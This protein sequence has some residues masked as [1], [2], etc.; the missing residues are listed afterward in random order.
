[1]HSRLKCKLINKSSKK[2][3]ANEKNS[4]CIDLQEK[5][6]SFPIL[7]INKSECCGCSACYS[8]CRKKAISM[9][10]DSKGFEYPEINK[11]K[12]IKCGMCVKVCPIKQ[13]DNSIL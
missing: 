3:S 5:T 8:I 4:D 10:P 11:N 1:M 6:E 2:I 13:S 9:I 7:Y 12:C